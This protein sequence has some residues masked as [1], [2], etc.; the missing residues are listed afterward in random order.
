MGR[1]HSFPRHSSLAALASTS[2]CAPGASVVPNPE[3]I[4]GFAP[5]NDYKL[6][7]YGPVAEYFEALA[8]S[9]DRM[10]L[11]QIGGSTFGEPLYVAAISTPDNLARL[12]RY[13]EIART[14]SY[15]RDPDADLGSVLPEEEA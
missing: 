6:A 9:S 2:A 1:F 3:E 15:A 4:I 13:K 7:S 5:E 10:V 11:E 14:L 12:D 8:A